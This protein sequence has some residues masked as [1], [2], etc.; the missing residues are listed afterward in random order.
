MEKIQCCEKVFAP[1][2]TIK[3]LAKL[4]QGKKYLVGEK[5]TYV[6]FICVEALESVNDV[7]EP[8]FETYASLKRYYEDIMAIP[9][10]QKYRNSE[11]FLNTPKSYNNKSARLGS[12]PFKK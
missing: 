1:Q 4:F 8:V 5:L 3:R 7:L 6:D 11:E 9:N 12:E 10:I 2:D